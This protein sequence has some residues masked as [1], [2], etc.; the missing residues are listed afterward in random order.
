[1]QQTDWVFET[2]QV[3]CSMWMDRRQQKFCCWWTP[4][5][6]ERGGCPWY[7]TVA[8]DG[9]SHFTTGRLG[10]QWSNPASGMTSSK[11]NVFCNTQRPG[12]PPDEYTGW[13]AA[14]IKSNDSVN[15]TF[16]INMFT[17][18]FRPRHDVKLHPHYHCHWYLSV[19]M[20]HEAGQS[21]FLHTQLYLS[22]NLDHILFGN[23]SWH[24]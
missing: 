19:L 1:M 11:T 4:M 17:Y 12:S 5:F 15:W 22:T 13:V 20:C 3:N 7:L 14:R 9:L 10:H 16:V 6:M 24:Y 2:Q 23:V 8:V 18:T 21:A